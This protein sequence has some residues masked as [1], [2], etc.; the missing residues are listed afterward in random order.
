[1]VLGRLPS[2]RL[3]EFTG[4]AASSMPECWV[5]RSGF[6][7]QRGRGNCA[8]LRCTFQVAYDSDLSLVS[9]VMQ[10]AAEEELGESMRAEIGKYRELLAH[11][12]VD[13]VEVRERPSVHF[14]VNTNTW[15][16]ATVR[17]SSIPNRPVG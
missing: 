6:D 7:V 4:H 8:R 5:D 13:E 2:N 10:G 1:L 14:R 16:D 12:P 3:P 9:E 11:T 17:S 15:L